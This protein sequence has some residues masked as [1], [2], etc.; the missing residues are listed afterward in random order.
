MFFGASLLVGLC[1][2]VGSKLLS[3]WIHGISISGSSSLKIHIERLS[4]STSA[5]YNYPSSSTTFWGL[6]ATNYST[7]SCSRSV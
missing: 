2:I 1:C 4:A 6:G 3:D 5:Q 7:F